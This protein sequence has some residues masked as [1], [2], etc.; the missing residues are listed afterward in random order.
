MYSVRA[1]HMLCADLSQKMRD[2]FVSDQI[3]SNVLPGFLKSLISGAFRVFRVKNIPPFAIAT[4]PRPFGL[5]P[6]T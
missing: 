1:L 2:I 4:F 5:E 3:A 6:A